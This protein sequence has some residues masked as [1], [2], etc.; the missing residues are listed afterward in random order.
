MTYGSVL[1]LVDREDLKS[2]AFGR[3]GASPIAAT[4]KRAIE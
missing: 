3:I 1:E 4:I 2:S